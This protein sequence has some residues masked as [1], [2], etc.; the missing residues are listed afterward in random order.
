MTDF[1]Y[2]MAFG[3]SAMLALHFFDEGKGWAAIIMAIYAAAMLM[4][5]HLGLFMEPAE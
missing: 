4:G 5:K 1:V 2:G 3:A